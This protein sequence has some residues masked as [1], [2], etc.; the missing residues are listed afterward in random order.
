M[1]NIE[2]PKNILE[3]LNERDNTD[4]DILEASYE[5]YGKYIVIL[6]IA[7]N[8]E[9]SYEW[10]DVVDYDSG[11]MKN[12]REIRD[13]I[14]RESQQIA[15]PKSGINL[16]DEYL[17]SSERTELLLVKTYKCRLHVRR[18]KEEFYQLA[19]T[20]KEVKQMFSGDKYGSAKSFMKWYEEELGLSKDIV[21]LLMKRLTLVETELEFKKEIGGIS[22]QG[23]K[24]L[25][26]KSLDP[27]LRREALRRVREGE[28]TTGNEIKEFIEANSQK[29]PVPSTDSITFEYINS[30]IG[31]YFDYREEL[32]SEDNYKVMKHLESIV[33]IV[34]KNKKMGFKKKTFK[35]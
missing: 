17:F 8:E 6:G 5:R 30:V 3:L 35:L 20:L 33:R 12:W 13:K 1:F 2:I 4:N 9:N 11:D 32:E 25:T 15:F 18:I 22:E 24:E 21:S 7:Y 16:K 23:I 31:E 10:Y 19:L 26:K 14:T 28:I 34:K 29:K 27:K